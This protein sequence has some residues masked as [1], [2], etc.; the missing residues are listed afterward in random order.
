MGTQVTTEKPE[1]V[2]PQESQSSEPKLEA[3]TETSPTKEQLETRQL[4]KTV[5]ADAERKNREL[6]SRIDELTKKQEVVNAP[7]VEEKNKEFYRDPTQ[8]IEDTVRRIVAPLEGF[9]KKVQTRDIYEDAKNKVKGDARFADKWDK[10]AGVVDN[11]VGEAVRNGTPVSDGLVYTCAVSAVGLVATGSIDGLSFDAP[12][13]TKAA[14]LNEERRTVITP[15]HLSPSSPPLPTN[16][17]EK[18]VR[19]LTENE[20]RVAKASGLT[21]EQYL[22][23]LESGEGPMR[24]KSWA[25]KGGK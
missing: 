6:M 4:V 7:T 16:R 5:L 15:P 2:P 8:V 24:L 9:V 17:Q 12:T 25:D 22:A 20:R 23:E 14:P 10:I 11:L 1:I 3:P 18:K 13:T 21:P 19:E